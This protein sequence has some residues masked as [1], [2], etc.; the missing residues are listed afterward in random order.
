[1]CTLGGSLASWVAATRQLFS[2]A[3]ESEQWAFYQG[4][5]KRIWGV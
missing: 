1:V 5:A 2:T 3:S 4:N